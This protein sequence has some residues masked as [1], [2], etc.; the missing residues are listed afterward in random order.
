MLISAALASLASAVFVS[1]LVSLPPAL[2]TLSFMACEW[3]ILSMA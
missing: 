1:A 3:T 2:V